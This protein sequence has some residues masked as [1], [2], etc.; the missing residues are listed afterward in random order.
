[1]KEWESSY[2]YSAFER[3]VPAKLTYKRLKNVYIYHKT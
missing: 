2:S 3:P 1:M